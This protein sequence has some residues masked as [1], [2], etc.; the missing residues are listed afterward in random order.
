LAA[1]ARWIQTDSEETVADLIQSLHMANVEQ[2]CHECSYGMGH[3]KVSCDDT[4]PCDLVSKLF[5]SREYRNE[6]L[7]HPKEFHNEVIGS[8]TPMV[9]DYTRTHSDACPLSQL[10]GED[11]E[12]QL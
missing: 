2:R 3:G 4:R 10:L 1:E 11:H 7:I 5:L 9:L 12:A 8:G 6:A